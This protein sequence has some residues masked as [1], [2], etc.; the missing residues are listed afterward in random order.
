MN[1]TVN[2]RS[3]DLNQLHILNICND[4]DGDDDV[5]DDD[6]GDDVTNDDDGDATVPMT[7]EMMTMARELWIVDDTKWHLND[8]SI[9]ISCFLNRPCIFTSP[10]V[11]LVVLSDDDDDDDLIEDDNDENLCRLMSSAPAFIHPSLLVRSWTSSL[12]TRSLAVI[13]TCRGH[14]SFPE[15]I[16]S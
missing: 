15:R 3:L 2:R 1:P 13:S 4:D 6:G 16:F 9:S 8:H 5:G 14:S 10:P 12:L 7:V 11:L